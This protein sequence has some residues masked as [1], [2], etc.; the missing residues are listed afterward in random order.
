MMA[1]TV[2]ATDDHEDAFVA[3]YRARYDP[4]V[5][6]AYLMVGDRDAA[7]RSAS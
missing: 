7:D 5:R 4:M 3:L 2:S 1:A 6:L